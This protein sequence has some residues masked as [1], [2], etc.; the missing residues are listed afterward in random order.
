MA[1]GR[2]PTGPR[3][4]FTPD[5]NGIHWGI[6]QRHES[7]EPWEPEE[8][9]LFVAWARGNGAQSYYD[10]CHCMAWREDGLLHRPDG[11]AVIWPDGYVV[12]LLNGQFHRPD[13]PALFFPEGREEWWLNGIRHTDETF[14]VEFTP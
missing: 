3:K 14:T 6:G 7:G 13:G 1:A 11:P 10:D 2:D 8:W 4:G 9:K 5:R 12:W